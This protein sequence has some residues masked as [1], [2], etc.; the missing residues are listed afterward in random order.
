MSRD[1]HNQFRDENPHQGPSHSFGIPSKSERERDRE[2][3][4][5]TRREPRPAEVSRR[6]R[7]ASPYSTS[8]SPFS[9]MRRLVEDMDRMF[10]DFAFGSAGRLAP[11]F[12]EELSGLRSLWTPA[13]ET[14]RRGDKLVV[15]AD[16]PGLR[17]EDVK[18]QIEQDVL[19]IEGERSE[20]SRDEDDGYY[21]TERSYGHFY[22]AIPLPE[23]VD[24]TACDAS[25]KDGVLEVTLNAPK[26]MERQ[27]RKIEIR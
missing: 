5:D 3:S 18:V 8:A 11:R 24:D 22:R 26:P 9:M 25:F 10:D 20:E 6:A 12:D 23:G 27:G 4:V 13:I 1:P 21:R 19:T 15:R 17:K 14:F 16:L 7:A 2:R